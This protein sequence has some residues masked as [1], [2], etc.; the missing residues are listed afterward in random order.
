MFT[1]N[2]YTANDIFQ[3]GESNWFCYP[4]KLELYYVSY[5]STQNICSSAL[6]MANLFELA[7]KES[8]QK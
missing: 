6:S 5:T 3:K 4:C 1:G 8:A 7:T 2:R